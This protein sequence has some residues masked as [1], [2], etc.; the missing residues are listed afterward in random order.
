MKRINLSLIATFLLS[1]A[2]CAFAA[3]PPTIDDLIKQLQ[4]E[5]P[6]TTKTPEELESAYKAALEKVTPEKP[7]SDDIALQ[8]IVFRA[9][10]PGAEKERAAL[11]F[12]MVSKLESSDPATQVTLLRHLQR[13]GRE[14]TVPA[15]AKLLDS[16]DQRVRECARRALEAN[17]SKPAADALRE[18]LDRATDPTWKTALLTALEYRR[19]PADAAVFARYATAEQDALRVPALLA[20]ARTGDGSHAKVIADARKKGSEPAEAAATDAYLVLADRLASSQGTIDEAAKMYKDLLTAAQPYRYAA[21]VGL[22]NLGAGE[23]N[24]S[25]LIDLL[26]DKDP[27]A[28]GATLDALARN[29]GERVSAAIVDKLKSASAEAK[30]ALLRALLEQGDKRHARVFIEA[31]SSDNEA[32][33]VQ[34]L[35]ALA[36]LGDPSAL[37]VLIKSA[38]A[39]G[40]EQKAARDALDLVPGKDIDDAVVAL[41]QTGEP[42]ARVEALR[43]V[44]TRGVE[45]AVP[46]LL[47]AAGDAE[48]PVRAEAIRSL[49]QVAD[50]P[51][52]PQVI[53]IVANARDDG[54]R[55]L[56]QRTLV[57]VARKSQNVDGRIAPI[58]QALEKSNPKPE[59]RAALIGALGQLGG[60]KALAAVKDAIKNTDEKIHEAGVR[61]LSAWPDGGPR[62][63]VLDLAKSEKKENLAILALRGYIRMTG[64]DRD[65]RQPLEQLKLLQ[66][67]LDLAKRPDEKKMILAGLREVRHIKTLEMLTPLLDQE[68]VN[69]EASDAAL[70]VARDIWEKEVTEAEIVKNAIRKAAEKTKSEANKK[71]ATE[72]L[73]KIRDK[74]KNPA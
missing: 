21:I 1:A 51:A 44:G 72:V 30:P 10:R 66:N 18:Q 56:A 36:V 3:D 52:L 5:A 16:Q 24:I 33:R 32:V 27:E 74:Q 39:K 26:A 22:G 49:A 4:G 28:R 50:Q 64:I 46:I 34:A 6:L 37:P 25:A 63:D 35:R 29:K 68:E 53:A 41:A 54:E 69:A 57:T 31:A 19:D 13:F 12:V 71:G 55:D 40:D 62:V 7:E 70:R 8:K 2:N 60:G 23:Q 9:S 58:L 59:T 38:Q 47:N 73:D 67:A 45:S 17:P 43:A 65:K 42:P 14:E 61:A 11:A 15:V 48:Q 20:L